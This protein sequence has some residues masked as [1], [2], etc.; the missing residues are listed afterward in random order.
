MVVLLNEL[1]LV[2]LVNLPQITLLQTDQVS[3][4]DKVR[5][6]LVVSVRRLCQISLCK[7]QIGAH[8]GIVE[9]TVV[10]GRFNA[11]LGGCWLGFHLT[12]A[13]ND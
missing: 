12:T 8:Q 9:N 6:R 7:Q 1:L 11:F 2:V 5:L 10:I 13:Y 3:I 4:V